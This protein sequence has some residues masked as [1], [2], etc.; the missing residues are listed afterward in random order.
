M[1]DHELAGARELILSGHRIVPVMTVDPTAAKFANPLPA[2]RESYPLTSIVLEDDLFW[3]LTSGTNLPHKFGK[4]VWT[5]VW[6]AYTNSGPI[7]A[8]GPV[9]TFDDFLDRRPC[10]VNLSPLRQYGAFRFLAREDATLVWDG[11]DGDR[12]DALAEAI[13]NGMSYRLVFEAED[14]LVYSLSVDLP[15]LFVEDRSVAITSHPFFAPDFCFQPAALLERLRAGHPALLNRDGP[16]APAASW[17]APTVPTFHSLRSDGAYFR[18][19]DVMSG[20]PK[21]W[22]QAR[23]YAF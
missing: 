19:F 15:M 18:L 7:Y 23:L 13:E 1:V 3:G 14:G 21:R 16:L 12:T 10:P 17:D 2:Y 9:R 6:L 11:A 4:G 8:S 22:K 20:E 5:P